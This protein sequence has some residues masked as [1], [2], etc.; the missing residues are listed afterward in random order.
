MKEIETLEGG[1]VPEDQFYLARKVANLI[2]AVNVLIQER[3]GKEKYSE[4]LPKPEKP[5]LLR[6]K[7]YDAYLE[8]YPKENWE[9]LANLAVEE[10]IRVWKYSRGR[11][12][13]EDFPTYLRR[14]LL[15]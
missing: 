2:G 10:C 8:R 6:Q 5:K 9:D 11:I 14:E 15:E 7:L 13:L 4:P 12:I 3:N 1:V